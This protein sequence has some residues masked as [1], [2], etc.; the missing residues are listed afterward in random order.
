M[1]SFFYIAYLVCV[2][3]F[4]MPKSL[5]PINQSLL[6]TK[7]ICTDVV[8][9]EKQCSCGTQIQ[10]AERCGKAA[11]WLNIH[12]KGSGSGN[13]QKK[14]PLGCIWR[15]D[16][17][18][19]FNART[20]NIERSAAGKLR[21]GE[22]KLVCASS[23]SAPFRLGNARTDACRPDEV[24]VSMEDCQIAAESLGLKW[25]TKRIEDAKEPHGCVHRFPD[26][27]IMFNHAA[28]GSNNKILNGERQL[29]CAPII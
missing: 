14:S 3:S 12:Y 23:P 16:G 27:D 20:W 1:I 2:S 15:K 19:L 24:Q 6:A 25:N 8:T 5:N 4:P 13:G 9:I 10:S 17:D 18:I 28:V 11:A 29:V 7:S 26:Q 21:I 22:R